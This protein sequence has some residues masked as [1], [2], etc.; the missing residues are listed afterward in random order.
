MSRRK[1]IHFKCLSEHN[2]YI[3]KITY[4]VSFPSSQAAV[5]LAMVDKT[6]DILASA[7]ARATD[8][9]NVVDMSS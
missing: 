3:R 6:G 4:F 7:K 8:T 1:Y 2:I 9:T 5:T